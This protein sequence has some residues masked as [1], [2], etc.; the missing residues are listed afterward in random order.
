MQIKGKVIG[1]IE[2]YLNKDACKFFVCV[3]L[4]AILV[5]SALLWVE[6]GDYSMFLAEWC[7]YL[8]QN[9]GFK[10]IITIEADY[11]A[12]YLYFLALFTYIPVKYLYSIKML[13]IIFDFILAYSSYLLVREFYKKDKKRDVYAALCYIGVLFMPTVIL[14]SSMWGQCDS[15]YASFIVLSIYC[16]I[17]K[18][19]SLSFIL[20]GIAIT[21]KLQAIF[22]LPVYGI[23]YL[24]NREFSIFNFAW[25]PAMNALL[26]IPAIIIGKPASSLFSAYTTQMQSYEYKTVFGYP[27]FYNFLPLD[28]VDL[29][30]PGIILTM[31][32]LAILLLIVLFSKDKISNKNI[33]EL[34]IAVVFLV[35]YFL[36]KMHDRYAFVAEVFVLIYFIISKKDLFMVLL[37]NVCAFG[38]YSNC[39]LGVTD[40]ITA[41]IAAFQTIIMI[42]YL[43]NFIKGRINI[44]RQVSMQ[45]SKG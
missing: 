43:Y 12:V 23:I 22:M 37:V 32:L 19:Y 7:D 38:V 39:L 5:R 21:F 17:T 28:A 42:F 15:I 34:S 40:A 8:K 20:Y 33:I 41:H 45:S 14:N 24:K 2:K 29:I 3:S 16:I 35:T 4:L 27:N 36:P 25:V 9:G 11:N 10:G 26:Y 13:S 18:K 6:S 1:S 44:S 30:K 31:I